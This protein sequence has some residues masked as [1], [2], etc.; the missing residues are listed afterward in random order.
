M[1]HKGEYYLFFDY[2][3]LI[4]NSFW[5]YVSKGTP[6]EKTISQNW[7]GIPNCLR[8]SRVLMLT[9]GI[10]YTTVKAK[11]LSNFQTNTNLQFDIKDENNC[12]KK[13]FKIQNSF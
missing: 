1:K 6:L 12:E 11:F 2:L 13:S 5:S 3:Y 7:K 8:A 10:L 9:Q 4:C